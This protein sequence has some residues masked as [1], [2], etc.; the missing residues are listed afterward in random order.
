MVI[1][2]MLYSME[3]KDATVIFEQLVEKQYKEPVD[4]KFDDVTDTILGS[5]DS[6]DK[7]SSEKKHQ[8]KSKM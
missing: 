3:N 5:N 7:E 2:R 1:V 4:G 8:E 6:Y